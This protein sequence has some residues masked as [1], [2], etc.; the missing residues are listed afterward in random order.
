MKVYIQ[1]GE[2]REQF[3][4]NP[5]TLFV[6]T[7]YNVNIDEY[8]L[9]RMMFEDGD[10]RGKPVAY[11]FQRSETK[12]NLDFF[13]YFCRTNDTSNTKIIMEHKGGITQD[14]DLTTSWKIEGRS[15]NVVK[16][17]VILSFRQSV[18]NIGFAI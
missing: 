17:T 2:I 15:E 14:E 7:T 13:D 12:E 6:D 4:K 9:L 8:P 11:C 5:E 10:G 3:H 18:I 1:T 16:M